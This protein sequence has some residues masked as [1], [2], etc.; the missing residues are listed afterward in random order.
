LVARQHDENFTC[1]RPIPADYVD[2]A[3]VPRITLH[4]M[5]FVAAD[6][7]RFHYWALPVVR[8]RGFLKLAMNATNS[9][10]FSKSCHRAS[11]F[12][13]A[14]RAFLKLIAGAAT[15]A[16]AKLY[17]MRTRRGHALS[18]KTSCAQRPP[19]A[20]RCAFGGFGR[21]ADTPMYR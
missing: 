7:A 10:N 20:G 18:V 15:Y 12:S 11:C 8:V 5:E 17:L 21:F 6:C 16:D 2:V 13:I 4:L 19:G 9:L 1:L 3:R 14:T